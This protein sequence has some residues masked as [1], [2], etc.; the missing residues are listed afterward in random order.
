MNINGFDLNA[1]TNYQKHL[2]IPFFQ[3]N[4]TS[5]IYTGI[6]S[7]ELLDSFIENNEIKW[8]YL[9]EM[10][11]RVACGEAIYSRLSKNDQHGISSLPHL[12]GILIG[13]RIIVA[14]RM[15]PYQEIE[16]EVEQWSREHQ[17]WICESDLRDISDEGK[18]FSHGTESH[19][20]V[21]KC[22]QNVWK[23][24]HPREGYDI[25]TIGDM[26][27]GIAIFNSIFKKTHYDVL[28]Y[29]RDDAGN[30]CAICKQPLIK[31]RTVTRIGIDEHDGDEKWI[32]QTYSSIMEK[33]GFVRDNYSWKKD[34]YSVT[35]ITG[36]NVAVTSDGH[37]MVID[38]DA[39]Y[40]DSA[41]FDDTILLD[42]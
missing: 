6:S 28:G 26:L 20:Y 2:F 31:G 7:Q 18:L 38:A 9:D 1:G 36:N 4:E 33:R 5:S 19:V 37:T 41:F 14:G 8:D 22:R 11:R 30:M 32:E 12:A 27:D 25:I 15:R 23:V 42:I 10:L 21:D 34:Q 35:D 40:I 3:D 16:T 17:C 39:S 24:M 29:G 13:E